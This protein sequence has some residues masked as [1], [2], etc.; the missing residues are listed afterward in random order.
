MRLAG[1]FVP[2]PKI[3]SSQ[4][5]SA[6]SYFW[7]ETAQGLNH[8]RKTRHVCKARRRARTVV[9]GLTLPADLAASLVAALAGNSPPHRQ[10]S[11]TRYALLLDPR[12][13]TQRTAVDGCP[14]GVCCLLCGTGPQCELCLRTQDGAADGRPVRHEAP[15]CLAAALRCRLVRP[16]VRSS[17]RPF[18]R[19][20]LSL[21][22]S[23]PHSVP[24]SLRSSLRPSLR[25]LLARSLAPSLLLS[26]LLPS[27]LPH[28]VPLSG[29][30][31]GS[32]TAPPRLLSLS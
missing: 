7:V 30:S 32:T 17:I 9:R 21:P 13:T 18:I 4:H 29:L 15:R 2:A 20:C 12:S 24:R 6:N 26:S 22:S 31:T 16:S 14:L 10:C 3:I 5:L 1:C 23:L 8:S 27:F 11:A 25:R 19:P 28:S